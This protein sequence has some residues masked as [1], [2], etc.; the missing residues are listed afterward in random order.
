MNHGHAT[1]L[2][3]KT[4]TYSSWT[5]MIQRCMNPKANRY[6]YYGGRGIS[7]CDHWFWFENFLEDM[8]ERPTGTSLERIDVNS[9]YD[10]ENCR[11]ATRSEQQRNRRDNYTY[12]YNNITLTL[13]AWSELT[14]L[15][16]EALRGRR[17]KGWP[18][19]IALFLP[20]SKSNSVLRKRRKQLRT[21]DGRFS[22]EDN[23]G[24]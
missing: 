17:R 10:P 13:Q 23:G 22:G 19:E 24:I 16:Y 1:R 12:T 9:G 8:G 21:D 15:S 3:G 14:G 4:A 18:P 20:V 5:S 7:V 6:A 2:N 11:W